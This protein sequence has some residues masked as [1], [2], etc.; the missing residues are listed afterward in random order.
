MPL[1]YTAGEPGKAKQ[2]DRAFLQAQMDLPAESTSSSATVS[3]EAF[4]ENIIFRNEENGYTVALFSRKQ[5]G[6]SDTPAAG[7]PIARSSAAGTPIARSS[8]AGTPLEFTAVGSMPFLEAGDYA[9]LAGK[10]VVH[11]TYGQQLQVENYAQIA[12]HTDRKSV[13]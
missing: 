12:P 11:G 1:E 9:S 7:T 3:L 13:V 2:T 8:A 5:L 4:C 10:W 6:S